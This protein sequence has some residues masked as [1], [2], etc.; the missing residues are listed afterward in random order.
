MVKKLTNVTSLTGNGLRDWLI[1]RITSFVM[2][3]YI[4]FLLS[5]FVLHVQMDYAIWHGLFSFA[6][7]RL[8][9]SLFLLSL[10]WH[11][12]IG[13]WTIITDYIKPL[14]L[15]LIIQTIIIIALIL[16]LIWGLAIFWGH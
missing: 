3:I 9:S 10:V 15:R 1:Q 2:L 11:A 5:F 12:W 14:A 16:Y 7:V 6:S 4:V 8:L 13:I